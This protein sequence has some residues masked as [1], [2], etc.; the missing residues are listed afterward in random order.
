MA[1]AQ[2]ASEEH[3]QKKVLEWTVSVAG[4]RDDERR[5]AGREREEP[6]PQ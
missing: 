6:P 1:L 5:H 3:E 2:G 4:T